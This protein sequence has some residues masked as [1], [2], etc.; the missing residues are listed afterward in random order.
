MPFISFI[1]PVYNTPQNLLI[2]CIDSIINQSDKNFEAIFVDDG[3]NEKIA[4][5][6]DSYKNSENIFIIHK[7]NGGVSSARNVGLE[8]ASGEYI[9]FLDADDSVNLDMVNV[10]R[11]RINETNIVYYDMKKLVKNEDIIS[12]TVISP[13]YMND[14]KSI[15]DKNE[16]ILNMIAEGY[17]YK[18]NIMGF[19]A[20]TGKAFNNNFLKENKISFQENLYIAEDVIF[21]LDCLTKD[22]RRIQYIPEPLYNRYI[23]DQSLSNSYRPDII[24]NDIHFLDNLH[25]IIKSLNINQNDINKALYKRYICCLRGIYAFD[26]CHKDNPNNKRT[27]ISE[28]K[29]I[30]HKIPYKDGIKNVDFKLLDKKRILFVVLLRLHLEPV[31]YKWLNK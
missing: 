25:R 20:C 6:L 29:K 2:K 28:M 24:E 22:N 9:I 4:Q 18:V 31:V 11:N 13:F 10:L 27:R 12:E 17:T 1:I 23:F 19:L 14:M 5:F 16:I 3:S 15:I 21:V 26:M 8:K 30:A 7:S